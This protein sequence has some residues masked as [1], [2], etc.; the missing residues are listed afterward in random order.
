MKTVLLI[1]ANAMCGFGLLNAVCYGT[2]DE[3]LS[4]G[5]TACVVA[6]FV[7]MVCGGLFA[8]VAGHKS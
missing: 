6:V 8:V 3:P 7:V 2:G 5:R 4:I 1:I